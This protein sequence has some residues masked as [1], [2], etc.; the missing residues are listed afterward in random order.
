MSDLK[1]KHTDETVVVLGNGPS[2]NDID[3]TLL[4]DVVTI[5][6]NLIGRAMNPDYLLW[7]EQDCLPGTKCAGI[8]DEFASTPG[9]KFVAREVARNHLFETFEHYQPGEEGPLLSGDFDQGLYWSRTVAFPAINLAYI[10]GASRIVLA[11][12]DMNDQSHFHSDEGKDKPYFEV[13][14]ERIMR[15]YQ[16]LVGFAKERGF[17]VVN[18]S[19]D[20]AVKCFPFMSLEAAVEI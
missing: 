19:M 11:G 4:N 15:D 16:R 6:V 14:A 9:R 12:I 1:N 8:F 18:V 20:S 7:L 17:E 5:G 13:A 3:L 10:L 2:I